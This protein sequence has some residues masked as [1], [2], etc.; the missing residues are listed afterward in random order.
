MAGCGRRF[1]VRAGVAFMVATLGLSLTSLASQAAA[2]PL[3]ISVQVGY[4]NLVK[5]GQ[6]MPVSVDITNSGPDLEATLEIEGGNQLAARGGG[7]PGGRAVYQTPVSLASGATKHFRTYVTLDVAGNVDV[8]VV[9]SGRVIASSAGTS[10]TTTGALVGVLSDLPTTLDVLAAVRAGGNAPNITHLT[11]TDLPDSSLVLRAFDLV[12]IDDFSTD[13]L[14]AAQRTALAD[15]VTNGGSLFLGTGGSWHKTLSGLPSGIVPMTVTGSTILPSVMSLGRL[16]NVEVAT[17]KINNGTVWLAE[18]PLPLLLESR[19]GEGNVSMATFDWNQEQV[20]GWVSSTTLLRQ[21]FVRAT[22][23]SGSQPNTSPGVFTKFGGFSTSLASKGGQFSQALSNLPALTLPAWWL[24]GSLVLIYVLLV[25][26][27][28]YFVLRRINRRALAWVTVPLI[29]VV[30]SAGAYGAGVMTKGTAVQANQVS[31][32]HVEQGWSHAYQEVYTGLITPT[33]GDYEVGIGNGHPL[34]SPIYYYSGG[35]QDAN[36]SLVRVNTA[37]DAISLPGMTA[38]NLRGFAT[39]GMTSAPRLVAG[40]QLTGG[41]LVGTIQNASAIHFT[42]GVVLSGSSYQ[43]LGPLQPNGSVS[44][45]LAPSMGSPFNGQPVYMTIYPN[46][47]TCCGGPQPNTQSDVEREAELKTAVLSTLPTSGF[48]GISPASAEPTVVLWTKQPF[49]DITVN[50]SHP[51]SFTQS[52]VVLTL[53]VVQI[54][55]GS[56]ASGVVT[57]RMVDLDATIQPQAGPPGVLVTQAGSVTYDFAPPLSPGTHLGS[58]SI[59]SSNQFNAKGLPTPNGAVSTLK[60][61]VWDW[62]RSAWVDVS[63]ADSGST[64]IPD[65]AINPTTGEVQLKISSDGTFTSGYLSLTGTV[66]K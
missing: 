33:R 63:Y 65:A 41:Q 37:T 55:A 51:R 24:I 58:A 34:V 62:S 21:A 1:A 14:T 57:G 29:A 45:S 6:W 49:Q 2:G 43:K 19:V 40:A 66:S 3:K 4:R 32:L 25:G 39:E 26:P 48:N 10:G 13:T 17:G 22:F 31:V 46:V 50:G 15:Y 35:L 52:A 27:I 64:Q 56:L 8:R 47:F 23:G 53:H 54:G 38:F 7:P 18:G 44:F 20:A 28:N 12:A 42:D 59:S 16:A 36:Q 11:G 5:L 30:G 60:G 61:Q 9:Q